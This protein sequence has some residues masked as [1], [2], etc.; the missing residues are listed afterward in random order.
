[1][2]KIKAEAWTGWGDTVTKTLTVDNEG[3]GVIDEAATYVFSRGQC[4]A[5]ALA[6]HQLT[7]WPIKGVGDYS[8][9]P[10]SPGHCINYSPTHKVYMDIRG[11]RPK[12]HS[13]Y[14]VV[15]RRIHPKHIGN[16][17]GYLEPNIEAAIPFAKTLL[18]QL[19]VA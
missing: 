3:F 15:N 17:A 14:K 1:M 19:K 12:P 9:S 7:G 2:T 5:L 18:R 10:L 11:I 8:D 16:M 6:V 4:H 13:T